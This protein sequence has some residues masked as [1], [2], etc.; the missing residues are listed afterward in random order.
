MGMP[1]WL[2]AKRGAWVGAAGAFAAAAVIVAVYAAV[3]PTGQTLPAGSKATPFALTVFSSP[4]L[5]PEVQAQEAATAPLLFD[6]DTTTQHVAFDVSSVQAAFESPQS[7]SAIKIFGPAPYLLS[8]KA[9]A[10]GSFQSIAGLEN[11]NLT[12]LPAAWNTF[13]A[14]A[15]VTTGKILLTLTPATGVEASGDAVVVVRAEHVMLHIFLAGPDDLHRPLD[16]FRD[17]HGLGDV[18]VFE[19][20]TEHAAQQMVVHHDL[21]ERQT[22]DLGGPRLRAPHDLPAGPHLAAV[23]PHV[24][25]A[26]D[27]L[28]RHMGEERRPVHRLELRRR[29]CQRRRGVP[30]L[31]SH[32]ARRFGRRRD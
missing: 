3:V 24:H 20:P 4:S 7:V 32:Y 28:H 19:A 8:V 1:E 6:R 16:L 23:R 5:P 2:R 9:D 15:P 21:V 17:A 18:V 13:T 29:A 25:R 11:L 27:R 26:V 22:G 30:L 14:A 31:A 10:G 12:A